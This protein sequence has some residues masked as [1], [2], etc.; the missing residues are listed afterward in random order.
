MK[1]RFMRNKNKYKINEPRYSA[2]LLV[3]NKGGYEGNLW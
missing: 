1:I 3:K 2:K